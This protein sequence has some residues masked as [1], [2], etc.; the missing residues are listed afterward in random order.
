M[1]LTF[2]ALIELSAILSASA[3]FQ[4]KDKRLQQPGKFSFVF[5][6]PLRRVV[7]IQIAALKALL[8]LLLISPEAHTST[9]KKARD[10]GMQEAEHSA[11]K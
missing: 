8:Y 7:Q 11:T 4:F 1:S 6:E 9:H 10:A 3:A 5:G 2:V